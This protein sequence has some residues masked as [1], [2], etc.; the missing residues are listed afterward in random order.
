[1]CDKAFGYFKRVI[2]IPAIYPFFIGFLHFDIH[3]TGQKPHPA[4]TL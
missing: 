3:S 1:M 2:V 4:N